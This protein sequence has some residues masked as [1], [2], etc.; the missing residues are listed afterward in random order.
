MVEEQ[1][2]LAHR[3]A[4]GEKYLSVRVPD[5]K[6]KTSGQMFHAPFA[7]AQPGVPEQNCIGEVLLACEF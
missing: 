7:P 3:V 5:R 1:R 6:R 4:G 2:A